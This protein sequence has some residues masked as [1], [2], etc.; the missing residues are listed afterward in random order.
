MTPALAFF[1]GG[2]VRKKNVLSTLNLSFIMVGLI[3]VQWVLFGYSLAFGPDVKGF[4][5]DLSWVG[6]KGV[7][8]NPFEAYSKTI[9]HLLFCAFQMMFAVITPALITGTIVDRVRFKTFLVFSFLWATL[10]YD[11]LAHWVWGDG[12]WLKTMGALDFAGGT[13][14]HIAAGFSALAIALAIGPR[15]S[16][17]QAPMEPHNIPFTVLGAGL[18]WFGWFGFNAGSSLAADGLATY[19]FVN[20]NTAAAAAAMSWMFFAWAGEK[21]SVLGIATGAVVGLVAIT[22]AAGFVTPMGAL[23]IGAVAAPISFYAIRLR[24]KMKL[25]DSL[26]VW[27]CHGMGGLTGAL[28]TGLLATKSVN[29]AGADGLFYGNP[30]QFMTQVLACAT[31]IVFVFVVTFVLAKVLDAIMGLRVTQPE[32]EVGLDLSE[33]GERAYS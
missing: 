33:H 27:A 19:A 20:T 11:P 2:M 14:V 5:G 28:M 15:K 32:E 17:L 18:L 29:E 24:Q 12:G 25:D 23:I 10:V 3:S 21:P 4:I 16:Y 13:V 7:D 22:P 6:L 1:Y 26:D 8:V 31:T 30:G 9:P